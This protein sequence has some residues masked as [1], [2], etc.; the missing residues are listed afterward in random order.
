MSSWSSLS[1]KDSVKVWAAHS[2]P[3]P[4]CHLAAGDDDGPPELRGARVNSTQ[5]HQPHLSLARHLNA[6][7]EEFIE[8]ITELPGGCSQLSALAPSGVDHLPRRL[9]QIGRCLVQFTLGFLERLR[10]RR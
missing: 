1:S 3:A 7:I 9:V 8:I 2:F 10:A 6:G 4:I 5:P